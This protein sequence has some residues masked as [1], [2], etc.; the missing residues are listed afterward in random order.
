MR[1]AR[2]ALLH[3]AAAGVGAALLVWLGPPGNDLAAHVYQRGAFI[4]HGF[5]FWN[6]FWYAGHYSFVTYSLLYYPLAALVGIKLLAV[7][8]TAVAAG[9]FASLVRREWDTVG[10]WPALAFTGVSIV[11]VQAAAFPYT[12]GFA[13]ALLALL[14]LGARRLVPFSICVLLTF[15]ASPL[16]FVLLAVVLAGVAASRSSRDMVRP[17]AVV[18]ATAAVG[19]LLWRAFP[20]RGLFPYSP[21][22]LAASL[23]FCAVGLLF[24]WRVDGARVL[25]FFFGIYAVACLAAFAIPSGLGE[26]VGRFRFVAIP[27][28][29]LALSL[30][31]WKPV[32][33]AVVALAL[34]TSWNL[35]PLA[36][37]FA[38]SSGDPSAQAAYWQPVV[39]YLHRELPP[40]YR[41]E[42]VDTSGHWPAVYLARADVPIVRGWFRQDDFPQNR[43]LYKPLSAAAYV[44]W[45]RRMGV[46][47]VVLTDAPADYSSKTEAALLRSGSSG[48]TTTLRTRH[49]TVYAVPHPVSMLTG[50]GSPR[51]LA[52]GS[53]SVTVALSQPGRYRLA[54][55]Y[56]PYWTSP[57]VCIGQRSDGMVELVAHRSGVVRLR[58]SVTASRAV[59]ALAGQPAPCA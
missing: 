24:T 12:L 9:A 43:I 17:G 30:R 57:G 59:A 22:Q 53:S 33:P 25:R 49:A 29:V 16:A 19:A 1:T 37:S 13:C 55:R 52:L 54:L 35:T 47:Y 2:P 32:V 23:A 20:D 45:L 56:S 14:A 7:A 6:N 38:R 41:V 40:S 8:S 28:A 51:V 18:L 50:P 11:G 48:L 34:A 46:A 42:A 10:P 58:F 3:A 5:T 31:S 21:A 44:S 15:A 26:N 36:Y 4:A 39:R 27:I